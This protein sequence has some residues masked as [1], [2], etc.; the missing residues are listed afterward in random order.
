MKTLQTAATLTAASFIA[1]SGSALAEDSHAGSGPAGF[2]YGLKPQSVTVKQILAKPQ[3]D[4][5]VQLSGKLTNFLQEDKFEFTDDNGDVIT[6][7]LDEDQNWSHIAKDQSIV[8][9]ADVDVR[10]DVRNA[11]PQAN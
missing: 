10:L 9:V 3:D 7:K 5:L 1:L 11:W 2:D 6:V 8:I 4:M